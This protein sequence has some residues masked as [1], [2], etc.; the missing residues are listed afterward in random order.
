MKEWL[1]N[2]EYVNYMKSSYMKCDVTDI[3]SVVLW[4]KCKEFCVI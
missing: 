2:C 3:N 4:D 1:S